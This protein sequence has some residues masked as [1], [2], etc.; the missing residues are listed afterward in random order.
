[1][2]RRAFAILVATSAL[3][4]AATLALW[5]LSRSNAYYFWFGSPKS[6]VGAISTRGSLVL[7]REN[8]FSS[9]R[10]PGKSGFGVARRPAFDPEEIQPVQWSVNFLLLRFQ[11]GSDRNEYAENVAFP[12]WLV[13]VLFALLPV[14]WLR[15][16]RKRSAGDR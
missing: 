6:E 15:L 14:I 13:A 3:L 8:A 1:M 10:F 11:N 7:Y 5:V 2:R 4:C 9:Y 16:R 12:F